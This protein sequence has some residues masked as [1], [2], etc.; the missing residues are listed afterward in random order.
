MLTTQGQNILLNIFFGP[1]INAAKAIGDR[2]FNVIN[3]FSA[4]LYIWLSLLRSLNH[5]LRE[6]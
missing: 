6:I 3:G 4:N 5:T 1:V 2:I